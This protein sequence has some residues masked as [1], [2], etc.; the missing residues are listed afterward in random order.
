MLPRGGNQANEKV[1]SIQFTVRFFVLGVSSRASRCYILSTVMFFNI[2]HASFTR[3]SIIVICFELPN[4]ND[5]R[6][7]GIGI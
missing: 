5:L 1:M 6:Y 4:F 7:T 2:A 3:H